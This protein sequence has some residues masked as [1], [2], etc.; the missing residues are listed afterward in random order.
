MNGIYLYFVNKHPSRWFPLDL[1]VLMAV[2]QRS[3]H[4]FESFLLKK[5]LEESMGSCT[6]YHF[7][8]ITEIMLTDSLIHHFETVPNSK[9]LQMTTEIGLLKD[10]F[11][12]CIENIEQFHLFPQWFP[13]AFFFKMSIYVGKG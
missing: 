1:N 8:H 7:I 5:D 11:T 4:D 3:S 9:K 12:D 2:K 10:F 6:C 13:K